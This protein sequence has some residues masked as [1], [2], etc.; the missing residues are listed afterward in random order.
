MLVLRRVHV[1]AQF[2]SGEPELSFEADSGERRTEA[3][4]DLP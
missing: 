2:V 3:D 4:L 1:A